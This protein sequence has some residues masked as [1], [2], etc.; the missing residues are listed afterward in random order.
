MR[1]I[2]GEDTRNLVLGFLVLITGLKQLGLMWA[3]S[4]SSFLGFMGVARISWK[5]WGLDEM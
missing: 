5:L 3:A 1:F 2:V 4:E